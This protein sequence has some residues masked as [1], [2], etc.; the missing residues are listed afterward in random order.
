MNDA[1][2]FLSKNRKSRVQMNEESKTV[3]SVSEMAKMVGLSRQRFHQLVGTTFP[4][5][6][7]DIA[8]R[9]PFYPEDLQ[10]VCLEVRKRNFGIDGRRVMF[11]S[12]HRSRD[13]K[14]AARRKR[15]AKKRQ[16]VAISDGLTA[17]GLSVRDDQVA[18]AVT[19][20]FPSGID[21]KD[22]G[23]VLREVFLFIKQKECRR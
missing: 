19:T 6:L 5:P 13:A 23:E 7:Y 10:K 1:V 20:L 17:L 12:G 21:G 16:Y 4:F 9:R 11:Y 18:A 14:P 15:P 3:V 8:T 22:E 2:T